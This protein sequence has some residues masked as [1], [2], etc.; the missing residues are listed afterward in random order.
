MS[1]VTIEQFG[2]FV[3]AGTPGGHLHTRGQVA[4]AD[5]SAADQA[6]IDALFAAKQP[7]NANLYYRLTRT[8]PHGPET[9]DAPGEAVPA[10]LVASVH[11]TLD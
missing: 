2:G 7:V 1:D 6:R 11:T 8:G 3:G 10:A 9:V 4:W 5:L